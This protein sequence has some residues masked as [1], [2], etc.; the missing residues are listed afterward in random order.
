M[1]VTASFA[2][3]AIRAAAERHSKAASKAYAEDRKPGGIK[4]PAT[5]RRFPEW[6]RKCC[7]RHEKHALLTVFGMVGRRK[8][9]F[10][11]H[12][13]RFIE[14]DKGWKV[15]LYEIYLEASP[16]QLDAIGRRDLPT[17]IS[18]HALER[19]FQRIGTINWATI[20][21][22]LAGATWF[23]NA[24]AT[25]YLQS[26]WKQCAIPAE[27]GI[28]VGQIGEDIIHLRTFLPDSDLNSK[29]RSLY[30]DLLAFSSSNKESIDKAALA[31][32]DAAGTAFS[33]LLE[34]G[35][36]GWLKDAY[37]PVD[38]PLDDAWRCR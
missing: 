23:L 13:P 21:D 31:S 36:H 16:G 5:M 22:C 34:S 33:D 18:G 28:L 7:A 10:T 17:Q 14:T 8:G 29:W 15:E 1:V 26:E 37:M 24:V 19:M 25:P 32:D 2:R 6:F 30:D 12:C 4:P 20:R 9:R 38:D 11:A 35:R 3:G 27:R